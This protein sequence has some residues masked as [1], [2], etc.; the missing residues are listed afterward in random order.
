MKTIIYIVI[1]YIGVTKIGIEYS[2]YIMI[3]F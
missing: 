1:G 2:F 3:S